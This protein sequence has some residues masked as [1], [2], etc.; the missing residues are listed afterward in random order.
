MPACI[1][2]GALYT[3]F[4]E[5]FDASYTRAFWGSAGF[6]WEQGLQFPG[7]ESVCKTGIM[8]NLMKDWQPFQGAF[9]RGITVLFKR[10]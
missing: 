1:S 4:N 5:E 8:Q 10:P 3:K 9:T 7:F 6:E 2:S